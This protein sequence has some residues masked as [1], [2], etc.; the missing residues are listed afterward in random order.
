MKELKNLREMKKEKS[1][2]FVIIASVILIIIN[3][4]IS[5][6]YD[7]RFWLRISSGIL[8]VISMLIT[9]RQRNKQKTDKLY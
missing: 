3:I 8:L 7:G 5:D 6:K 1:A 2:L 9:I 4:I